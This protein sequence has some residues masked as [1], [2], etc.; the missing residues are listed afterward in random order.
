MKNIRRSIDEW[1]DKLDSYW[2][3]LTIRKQRQ[4][5]LYFFSVYAMLTAG[6]LVKVWYDAQGPSKAITIRHIENPILQKTDS[7]VT[8]QQFTNPLKQEP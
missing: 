4:Y 1:C 7:I 2:M 8:Q 3:T 5:T 6:I